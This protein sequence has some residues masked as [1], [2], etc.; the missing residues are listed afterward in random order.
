MAILGRRDDSWTQL[1]GLELF[2]LADE[3]ELR[4]VTELA[5]IAEVDEGTVLTEEAEFQGGDFFV[6]LEG[7]ATV[8]VHDQQLNTIGPGSFFGEM[9]ALELRKRTATVAA[10]SPMR[11]LVFDRAGFDKLLVEAPSV[12]RRL[13]REMGKRLRDLEAALTEQ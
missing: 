6:I 12:T 9:A 13:L 2:A 11:L 8:S 3:H 7:T 4:R 1:Q 10:A 5:D